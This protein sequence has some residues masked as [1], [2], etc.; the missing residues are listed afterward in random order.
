MGLLLS[1]GTDKVI[2]DPET[3]E[4][5]TIL[6]KSI[7][8][9]GT[10][11]ELTTCYARI[12]FVAEKDGKTC[13]VT[14]STYLDKDKYEEAEIVTTSIAT[15]NFDFVIL[16]TEMQSIDVVFQYSIEKF[17]Q[18]GYTAEIEP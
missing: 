14:F 3:G 4:E 8:I 15:N 13:K 10:D 11:I 6:G 17:D 5:I 12:Q 18:L 2:I 1:K 16:E 9:K 7:F